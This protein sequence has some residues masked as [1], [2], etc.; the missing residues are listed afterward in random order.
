MKIL[1]LEDDYLYNESLKEYLENKGFIVDSFFDGEE[2]LESI[3][4][5]HYSLLILDI[6]VPK[7]NGYEV[8]KYLNEIN[9]LTPRIIMTSLVDIDNITIGYELGC[10]DYLKKPFEVKELELR[11]NQLLT[12]N[13]NYES[14]LKIELANNYSFE[15]IKGILKKEDI[16]IPL[17]TRE[18]EFLT[19]LIENKNSYSNIETLRENVW[20]GKEISHADIRMYVLKIRS[21]TYKK[22]ILSSRSIGYKIA[23]IN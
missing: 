15:L 4:E 8:I 11:I 3:I 2:A 1:L 21:K 20:E 14:N 23:T 5:N 18:K 6:K 17:T 22:F 12:K 19:F 7:L 13:H 9:D 16:E 10:S